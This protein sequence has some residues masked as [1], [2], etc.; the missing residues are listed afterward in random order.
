MW[1]SI[2][3]ITGQEKGQLIPSDGLSFLG[4]P[5]IAQ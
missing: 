5:G 1:I 4:D 2:K 3:Q